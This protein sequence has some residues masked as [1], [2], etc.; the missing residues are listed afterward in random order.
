MPTTDKQVKLTTIRIDR[1][2]DGNIA[3]TGSIL[4][5]ATNAGMR[6]PRRSGYVLGI[7]PPARTVTATSPN[8]APPMKT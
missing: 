5:A 1:L 2:T 7:F 3:G 8:Q 4:S 6:G